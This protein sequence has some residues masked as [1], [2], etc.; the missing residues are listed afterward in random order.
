MKNI[1]PTPAYWETHSFHH[2]GQ[3]LDRRAARTK[4][5]EVAMFE[6][7]GVAEHTI[8]LGR[9]DSCR[10]HLDLVLADTFV[11]CTEKLLC[12]LFI[13]CTVVADE[14]LFC[15]F[16]FFLNV[17]AHVIMAVNTY[18]KCKPA[19]DNIPNTPLRNADSLQCLLSEW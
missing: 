18:M 17:C 4:F 8:L 6:W 15:H 11:N 1:P 19:T 3:D 13:N 7:V 10:F 2:S 5:R 16:A 12:Q 14:L 9:R